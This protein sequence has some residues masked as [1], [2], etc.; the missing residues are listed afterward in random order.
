MG[1]KAYD[2]V[3]MNYDR[4]TAPVFGSLARDLVSFLDPAAGAVVLDVGCG[5]GVAAE[6]TAAVIGGGGV[7]VGLDPSLPMLT[8]ARRRILRLVA[9]VC[10]GLPFPDGAFDVVVANLVLSH[11]ADLATAVGDLFRVL[12]SGGSLGATA[13]AEETARDRAE[14]DA[15]AVIAATL[16][17]FELGVEAPEPA[18]PGEEWLRELAHLRAAFTD[19][20]FHGVAMEERVYEQRAP[21]IDYLGSQFWGTRGR[22]LRSITD[23][24]T[25]GRFWSTALARLERGFPGGV[26]S[27]SR[28]RL[29]VGTKTTD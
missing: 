4:L 8:R 2:S 25:W 28:L 7:V 19:A 22:Y 11:F 24:A 20:G 13:W 27:V 17:E 3:A 21:V 9:G 23:D 29:A 26:S 1:W 14:P 18:A 5:T 12:R 10:P 15:Y 6:A 16:D